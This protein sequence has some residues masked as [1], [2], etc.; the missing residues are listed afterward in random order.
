MSISQ[1]LLYCRVYWQF[2]GVDCYIWL[3]EEGH[4][5]DSTLTSFYE[6]SYR[7]VDNFHTGR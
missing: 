4:C 2:V 3:T 7:F 1:E 6:L 5:L